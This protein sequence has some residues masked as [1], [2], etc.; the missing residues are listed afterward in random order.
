M[1]VSLCDLAAGIASQLL[2]YILRQ[3]LDFACMHAIL[4]CVLHVTPAI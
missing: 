3:L 1:E 2:T 4:A